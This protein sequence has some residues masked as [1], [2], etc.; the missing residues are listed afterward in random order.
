MLA[1]PQRS[2]SEPEH[3]PMGAQYPLSYLKGA[4]VVLD[5]APAASSLRNGRLGEVGSSEGGEEANLSAIPRPKK[6]L[7]G[8]GP[9][10]FISLEMPA[11]SPQSSAPLH[12]SVMEDDYSLSK[13]SP[14]ASDEDQASPREK[15]R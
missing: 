12:D 9:V 1:K 6:R 7:I 11:P 10:D 4:A 13:L 2:S 5:A 15:R 3:A 14:A 8:R